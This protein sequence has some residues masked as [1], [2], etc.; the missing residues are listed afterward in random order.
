MSLLFPKAYLCFVCYLF[1]SIAPIGHWPRPF[2]WLA[3]LLMLL[4]HAVSL[5]DS[6]LPLSLRSNLLDLFSQIEREFEN[7]YIENLECESSWWSPRWSL[8]PV[9]LYWSAVQDRTTPFCLTLSTQRNRNAQRS[10]GCRRSDVWRRR[11]SQRSSENKR[12]GTHTHTHSKLFFLPLVVCDVLIAVLFSCFLFDCPP[13]ASH[14]TSQLS[15]KLKTTYKASTSKVSAAVFIGNMQKCSN[16]LLASV[17]FDKALLN[18]W[19]VVHRLVSGL[20]TVD[21]TRLCTVSCPADVKDGCLCRP[22]CS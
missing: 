16:R 1:I 18:M 17:C 9:R 10:F 6:K 7:L 2:T 4:F 20:G 14:S 13:T 21:W 15:Q 5:Q 22:F 11:F 19:L 8:M 12:W 3:A